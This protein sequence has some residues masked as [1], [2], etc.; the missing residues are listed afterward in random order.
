MPCDLASKATEDFLE[1]ERKM[2]ALN[3]DIRLL[4]DQEEDA[5]EEKLSRTPPP[6]S[7]TPPHKR[8][9][10]RS[11]P[12]P[13]PIERC[14]LG[15]R[16]RSYAGMGK[17]WVDQVLPG[18]AA[19]ES[20][21]L[22]CGDQIVA[23]NG[24]STGDMVDAEAVACALVGE[25]GSFVTMLVSRPGAEELRFALAL[26]RKMYEGQFDSIYCVVEDPSSELL[27][28]NSSYYDTIE[29]AGQRP[30]SLPISGDLLQQSFNVEDKSSGGPLSAQLPSM[31]A[32]TSI[33][34]ASNNNISVSVDELVAAVDENKKA[35]HRALD[36]VSAF[37]DRA[38][39]NVSTSAH[40]YSRCAEE[41]DGD[42]TREETLDALRVALKKSRQDNRNKEELTSEIIKALRAEVAALRLEMDVMAK[43]KEYLVNAEQRFLVQVGV[44]TEELETFRKIQA[45]KQKEIAELV[46][47][48]E[49]L[50]E[51]RDVATKA[52][53][54]LV[55][56][57]SIW[58]EEFESVCKLQD[59]KD[60]EVA[61]MERRI[62]CCK[63]ELTKCK[64]DLSQT[65]TEGQTAQ[66]PRSPQTPMVLQPGSLHVGPRHEPP[67]PQME[68]QIQP[69]MEYQIRPQ[70]N[71]EKEKSIKELTFE[72]Y[73]LRE[74]MGF[75]LKKEEIFRVSQKKLEAERDDLRQRITLMREQHN[76]LVK[77][78]GDQQLEIE[79][80]LTASKRD[81][82]DKMKLINKLT[83][84]LYT[85][86]GN[87]STLTAELDALRQRMIVIVNTNG[88]LV[89]SLEEALTRLAESKQINLLKSMSFLNQNDHVEGHKD[90]KQLEAHAALQEG[91][92]S[93]VKHNEYLSQSLLDSDNSFEV[94]RQK[95]AISIHEAETRYE[96]SRNENLEKD[97]YIQELRTEV[98]ALHQKLELTNN[99]CNLLI[100]TLPESKLREVDN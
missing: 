19:D 22:M 57:L 24:N 30:T 48:K 74:K 12:P 96:A 58:T 49:N 44:W 42:W 71:M 87:A 54:E 4:L 21:R 91:M 50:T 11:T 82:V 10:F 41:V 17:L 53:A 33:M 28:R 95:V 52:H 92:D 46:K 94:L 98:D 78:L 31:R 72:L 25:E 69:Q 34:V 45:A 63:E 76:A 27:R 18:G 85:S 77:S 56:Q 37:K 62:K 14:G 38:D 88:N 99:Q 81:N 68:Y 97:E 75:M 32:T 70:D 89:K 64:S 36:E 9:P 29:S 13:A 43:D 15:L 60:K 1:F 59:A 6:A 16:L 39:E 100:A 55:K 8:Q 80:A 67:T 2:D 35:L 90:E 5:P 26:E 93:I 40:T 86:R 79:N 47:D 66:Q 84:E 83:G 20:G 61:E 73:T 23:I 51:E 65:I 7:S 3:E